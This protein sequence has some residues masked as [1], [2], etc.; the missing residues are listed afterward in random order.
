MK[1]SDSSWQE[2]VFFRPRQFWKHPVFFP[3]NRS[4][5]CE[6]RSRH[7]VST[8]TLCWAGDKHLVARLCCRATPLAVFSLYLMPSLFV[9]C[10]SKATPRVPLPQVF[11]TFCSASRKAHIL[12]I[13]HIIIWNKGPGCLSNILIAVVVCTNFTTMSGLIYFHCTV[14]SKL[15]WCRTTD[16]FFSSKLFHIFSVEVN[17][18]T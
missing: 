11:L 6:T 7:S 5:P 18:S 1:D 3:D 8:N 17:Q 2:E 15:Y 10:S 12:C 9:C 13:L 14:Y 4:E 16:F